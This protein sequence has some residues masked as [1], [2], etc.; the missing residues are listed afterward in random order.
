[1]VSEV[2]LKRPGGYGETRSLELNPDYASYRSR[3]P[4]TKAFLIA[5]PLFILGILPFLMQITWF[6]SPQSIAAGNNV[7]GLQTDYTFSELGMGFMGES[8]VFDFK[9]LE[10]GKTVGPF[11]PLAVLFSM[12]VPL[13]IALFF[14]LSYSKKTK[15][16]IKT[17]NNTKTLENEFANS[18]F[19]LG[20][21]LGDG[22]P[23]EIAFGRV[24][25]STTGQ[26]SSEFF[27]VVSKNIQQGGMD[28]E[29]AVFDGRR[30]AIT[31]FPS[32]LIATSMRILI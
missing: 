23:A 22:L 4:W 1:M 10:N 13:S 32:A 25:E 28:V 5:L 14:S 19:Q 21:R 3:K 16:L 11:G 26:K 20:N 31:Y 12:F 29:S 15:Q 30:G 8:K 6:M 18:L 2:L 27:L 24:A 7:F 17:R 9:H